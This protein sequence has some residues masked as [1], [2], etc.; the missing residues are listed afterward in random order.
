MYYIASFWDTIK[1]PFINFWNSLIESGPNWLVAGFIM[2]ATWLLSRLVKRMV[3]RAVGKVSTHGHI[4]ILI[5]QMAGW[6]VLG[7][8]VILALGQIG[9]SLSAA[10]AA[11]GLASVGIGFAL[12]DILSNLFA[13]I[14]L[15]MQHPFTIGDQVRIGE[16][17]GVVENVRV[18]DTQILTY[19]GERVYIPNQ[20]V[21]ANPIINY[22]STPALRLDTRVSVRYDADL[23]RTRR[24]LENIMRS[25]QG[26]LDNPEPV[27]L[28]EAEAESVVLVM[29]FWMGSD[30]NR[31][32][33]AQSNVM[34][35]TIA[36]FSA[37]GI[38]IPYP[39]RVIEFHEQPSG[40][41]DSGATG[42]LPVFRDE[43]DAED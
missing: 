8:G 40:S 24:I 18:R 15:L 27:V 33:Q 31:R 19:E 26:I 32:L 5:A 43:D 1:Q 36:A 29:R 7:I 39:I 42:V 28:I 9:L 34:E 6:L 35:K 20:T 23:K 21:F 38:E 4:N 25:E 14:I 3:Q 17:E 10:L 12:K 22:T 30:R 2:L 16:E 37:A 11:V 41:G 13:G